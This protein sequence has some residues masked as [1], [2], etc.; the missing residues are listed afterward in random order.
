MSGAVQ[1]NPDSNG[2]RPAPSALQGIVRAL[3]VSGQVICVGALV[4]LFV[5]LMVNVVLRYVSGQGL[6]WAYDIHAILLPWMIAGGVVI[7]TVY[8]RNIAITILPDLLSEQGKKLLFIIMTALTLLISVFV[9]WSSFPIIRAAQFQK[10]TALGGISQL[11]GYA[12]LVYGFGGIA[13]ICACD[14]VAVTMGRV[15][16]GVETAS[17]L[18]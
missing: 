7:A 2:G 1:P 11:W 16:R 5:A 9:V 17:S 15:L 10:I 6:G 18:S 14:L 3:D 13:V 4:V 12:S 8:S